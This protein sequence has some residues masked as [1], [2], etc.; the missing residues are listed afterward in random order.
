MAQDRL[1]ATHVDALFNLIE[2]WNAEIVAAKK[3]GRAPE[4]PGDVRERHKVVGL[5]T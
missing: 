1:R 2:E 3:E 4:L 5:H